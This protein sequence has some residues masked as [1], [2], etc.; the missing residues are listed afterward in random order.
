METDTESQELTQSDNIAFFK[1]SQQGY[2]L[3]KGNKYDEALETFRAILDKAPDN[4]YALVG[5]GDTLRKKKQ[6]EEA[7]PYYERCL[8]HSPTN[9]FALF[10]VADVMRCRNDH[11][12]AVIYWKKYLLYDKENVAVITRVADSYRRLNDVYES[13]KYYRMTLTIQPKNCYALIGLGWLY[14]GA[15]DFT[16]ALGMWLRALDCPRD[17]NDIRINTAIGNCYYKLKKYEQAIEQYKVAQQIKPDDF[18]VLFGLANCYRGIG[19]YEQS[20]DYLNKILKFD[21]QNQVIL[22]RLGDAY[23]NMN[24]YQQA[25]ECY[26]NALRIRFDVFAVFGIARLEY[27]EGNYE[28]AILKLIGLLRYKKI[29]TRHTSGVEKIRHRL[30]ANTAP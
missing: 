2:A 16:A 18:Y 13:E 24:N 26:N 5:I 6:Y 14:F 20:M 15:K 29:N 28:R 10:G 1:L 25:K 11:E 22:S 21:S 17:K 30:G 27:R 7:L 12:Q 19:E 23:V 3:L 8:E 4:N 9:N